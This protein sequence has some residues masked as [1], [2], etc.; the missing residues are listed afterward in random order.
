[1][2]KGMVERAG[3]RT[4]AS[5]LRDMLRKLEIGAGNLEG[6][7]EGV[8]DVLHLRDE[9]QAEMDRLLEQGLNLKSEET[10]LETVDAVIARH[11]KVIEKELR[12]IGGL[13]GARE[14][15]QPSEDKTW[16]FVDVPYYADKKR[17]KRTTLISVAVVLVVVVVAAYVSNLLWGPNAK[18]EK[19]R[20]SFV[21]GQQY[22]ARQ[23]WDAAIE[24]FQRTLRIDKNRGEAYVYLGV[25]YE[26]TDQGAKAR[27]ALTKAQNALRNRRVYLETL[28]SAYEE[29]DELD[30]AIQQLDELITL[31]PKHAEAHLRRAEIYAQLGDAESAAKDFAKAAEIA[32]DQNLEKVYN[33]A[34][35]RLGIMIKT[36]TPEE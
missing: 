17:R 5:D 4:A 11:A 29:V 16:W 35:L 30:L 9:V 1:M 27:E 14:K 3:G 33:Q 24:E 12:K 10:R 26:I 13:A 20:A 21:S 19:A 22:M 8:L 36:L 34:K 2:P 28:A 18:A 32:E 31:Q 15:E 7:G 6:K 25:L 23:D